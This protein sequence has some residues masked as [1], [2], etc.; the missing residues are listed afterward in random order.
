MSAVK[1][2]LNDTALLSAFSPLS[3]YSSAAL[4]VSGG[5]D[6][7]AMM[8]LARRWA[9]LAGREQACF[10]ILTVDHGLRPESSAEAQFVAGEAKR[11]GLAHATLS[12]DGEKPKTGIQAAAR[13]AR[14]DLMTDW[15]RAHDI[16]CLVTAHTAGD[17]AETLLM[18]LSRGS[19]LDGL[20]GMAIVSER[21]GVPIV[22]PLLGLSKARLV[23]YLRA[24]AAPFV[25]DPSNS[26]VT[27]ERVRL[28]QAM[29]ACSA[30]GITRSA[31]VLTASRLGRSREAL[32]S[33]AVAFLE[34]NFSVTH[35][36]QGEIAGD[37]FFALPAEIGLRVLS[38]VLTLIGGKEDSP[39][40]A[41]A[42]RLLAELKAGR[43]QAALGGCLVIAVSGRLNFYRE[44]GRSRCTPTL[45][46]PGSACVW[47]GRFVLT[48]AA[49][50]SGN[51]VIAPLGAAGWTFYRNALNRSRPSTN[52]NRLAALT[53]P[54][55]WHGESMICAPA[56]DVSGLAAN[57]AAGRPAHTQLVPRLSHFLKST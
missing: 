37:A 34:H 23:A 22:R 39:E 33:A 35:L 5:P 57:G 47:D 26:N 6:S 50:L 40:M 38:R 13:H 20:A 3:A 28:R 55:L 29:K 11:L 43:R 16:A 44:P 2:I 14:Y 15:C 52:V 18:R 51:T 54:A 21:G 48:F 49:D 12:W 45:C 9:F 32:S 56:L 31:L 19:G 27:F 10:T 1:Q 53:S 30:A 42:E 17:Q 8:H 46:R 24:R 36:G 25:T 4:A 7:V 41:K